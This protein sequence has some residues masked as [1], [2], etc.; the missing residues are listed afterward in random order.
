VLRTTRPLLHAV[1]SVSAAGARADE[2][3]LL[4]LNLVALARLRYREQGA[5]ACVGEREIETDPE[6]G[7]MPTGSSTHLVDSAPVAQRMVE[8][9]A[10]RVRHEA[11]R[12]EEVALARTVRT[13]EER[14]LRRANVAS[15]DA[16]VVPQDDPSEKTTTPRGS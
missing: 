2:D 3:A 8:G 15:G 4:P 9:E 12:I 10:Q 6:V 16:L 13:H 11:Q 1:G 14:E 7:L 5:A